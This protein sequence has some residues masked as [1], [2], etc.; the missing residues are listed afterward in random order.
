[1]KR[2]QALLLYLVGTLGQILLVSLLV[3]LLRAGGVRGDYGTPIG[4]FTLCQVACHQPFGE[5][6]LVSAIITPVLNSLSE[7]F[8]KSN[9]LLLTISQSHFYR[10]GF[11]TTNPEWRYTYPSLVSPHNFICKS[12]RLWWYRRNRLALFFPP[13]FARKVDLSSV[14]ALYLCSLVTMAYPLFFTLMGL[15]PRFIYCLSCQAY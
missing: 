7:I 1:M 9:K 13:Y 6:L 14:H 11:F 8:S 10:F 3:W 2:K 15:W 12:P 5:Q 4:L